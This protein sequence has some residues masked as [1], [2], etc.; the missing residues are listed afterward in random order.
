MED[1]KTAYKY[2]LDEYLGMNNIGDMSLNLG[3]IIW[4]QIKW[5]LYHTK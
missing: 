1:G 3:I 4:F 2:L 5:D